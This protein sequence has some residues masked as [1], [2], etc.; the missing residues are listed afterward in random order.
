MAEMR[1]LQPCSRADSSQLAAVG[2][3][4]I[5]ETGRLLPHT[6]FES[7]HYGLRHQSVG[8]RNRGERQMLQAAP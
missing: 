7:V 3:S 8:Q 6:R 4:G 1:R 2:E 5:G